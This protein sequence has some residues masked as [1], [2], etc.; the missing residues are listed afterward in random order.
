MLKLE[1]LSRRPEVIC[2]AC[3]MPDIFSHQEACKRWYRPVGRGILTG[4]ERKVLDGSFWSV[5]SSSLPNASPLT[6]RTF[7]QPTYLAS[8]TLLSTV[9]GYIC[10]QVLSTCLH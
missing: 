2:T 4:I 6:S 7:R 1:R 8:K 10:P 9:R 3:C 5:S